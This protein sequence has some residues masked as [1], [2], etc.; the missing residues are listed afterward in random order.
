LNL[1]QLFSQKETTPPTPAEIFSAAQIIAR[2]PDGNVPEHLFYARLWAFPAICSD[3]AVLRRTDTGVEVFL[4]YRK[5]YF[6]DGYHLPGS[7]LI[8]GDTLEAR[9][10]SV[11]RTE[12]GEQVELERIAGAI[13]QV[14]IARGDDELSCPRGY[15]LANIFALWYKSGELKPGVWF[16]L[17]G[18]YEFAK[19]NN[20]SLIPG[21]QD[22]FAWLINRFK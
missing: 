11:I 6:F 22:E 4:T 21:Q 19:Q 7:I 12:I 18:F 8:S 10:A 1:S 5:D 15:V 3:A 14:E 16:P 2:L 17:N 20:F 13:T 9:L